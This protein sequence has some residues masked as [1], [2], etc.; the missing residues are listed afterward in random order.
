VSYQLI[1]R[2]SIQTFQEQ[3]LLLFIISD[4]LRSILQQLNELV[5]ILTHRH[6]ALLQT[7]ELLFLELDHSSWNVMRPKVVLEL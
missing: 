2:S 6:A 1:L 3:L 5:T 7:E 4:I